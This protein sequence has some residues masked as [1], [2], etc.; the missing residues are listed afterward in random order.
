M[1]AEQPGRGEIWSVNLSPTRGHE[2][3]GQ[4]PALVVSVDTFNQGPADLVI[5][6]PLT[7]RDRGISLHVPVDPP[8]GGLKQ[9]SVV[10]CD[11]IRAV[12]KQRLGHRWGR[13]SP[14]IMAEVEDRLRVLIG[15]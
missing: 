6:A 14:E 5:V 4:R 1:S 13:V 11:N 12:S 8:E 2:Q 9:R 10:K 15:L 7:T 3:A